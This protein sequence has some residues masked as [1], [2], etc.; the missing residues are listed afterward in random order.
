M[1]LPKARQIISQLKG[2]SKGQALELT[3]TVRLFAAIS[4]R[5]R[6]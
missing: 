1:L 5:R 6:A 3:L 4:L 2:E